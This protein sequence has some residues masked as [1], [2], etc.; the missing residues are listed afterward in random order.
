MIYSCKVENVAYPWYDRSKYHKNNS[1]IVNLPKLLSG[2]TVAKQKTGGRGTRGL[3][4]S[5]EVD[6]VTIGIYENYLANFLKPSPA[7]KDANIE[8][9]IHNHFK[10]G[11][12]LAMVEE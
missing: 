2:E 5:K 11:N 4:L 8:F 12:T 7:M 6:A 1:V 10:W 9:S 3:V